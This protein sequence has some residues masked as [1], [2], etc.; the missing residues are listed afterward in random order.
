MAMRQFLI[1]FIFAAAT[2]WTTRAPQLL[3]SVNAFVPFVAKLH[4]H[5]QQAQERILT[6]FL[7]DDSININNNDSSSFM[8]VEFVKVESESNPEA[9]TSNK[10]SKEQSLSLSS[11]SKS[12][13]ELSLDMDPQW[14]EARIPFCFGNEYIDCNVAFTVDLDDTTY[15]IAVP[16]D[17]AVAIVLESSK[18]KVTYMDPFQEEQEELVEIMATQ[19]QEL[20]G[21]D[22]FLKRTPK[23]LT[24]S[25]NLQHYISTQ[26]WQD[27]LFKDTISTEDLLDDSDEGLDFFYDFIKSELGEEEFQKTINECRNGSGETIDESVLDLFNIPGL[28]NQQDDAA[29]IEEMLKELAKEEISETESFTTIGHDL[30]HDGV[31]LKLIGFN[32]RNGKSYSLVKLLKPFTIVGRYVDN[33]D[34]DDLRFEL[35]TRGQEKIVIPRLEEICK[36][37]LEQSGLSLQP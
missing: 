20:L 11:S 30:E 7:Y 35:L 21:D 10:Q 36:Q 9:T 13:L 2:Y 3:T 8:D 5:G 28:G 37:D 6:L 29:G 4:S 22:V 23:I 32:F 15:G 1:S 18:G 31:A 16:C 12:L 25:G 14:K 33:G 17:A 24:I 19:L 34:K 27:E 26:H